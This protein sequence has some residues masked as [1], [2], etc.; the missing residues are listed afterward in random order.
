MSKT[1]EGVGF[2]VTGLEEDHLLTIAPNGAQNIVSASNLLPPDAKVAWAHIEAL[3][4]GFDEYRTARVLERHS[5][6]P[7]P[8]AYRFRIVVEYD[9]LGE[10]E[11]EVLLEAARQHNRKMSEP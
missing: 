4:D 10:A 11:T 6:E 2:A 1:I 7:K 3:I 5:H 9:L 8:R